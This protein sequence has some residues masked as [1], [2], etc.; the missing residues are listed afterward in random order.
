LRHEI[1]TNRHPT[2][3]WILTAAILLVLMLLPNRSVPSQTVTGSHQI[4]NVYVE[5]LQGD[6]SA[7]LIRTKLVQKLSRSQRFIIVDHVD[8]SDAILK[9]SAALWITGYYH[10]DIRNRYRTSGDTPVYTARL[11]LSLTNRQGNV[12]WSA[13]FKPRF[14]GSQYA[15]DNVTN[16]AI[17]HLEKIVK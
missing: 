7:A 13:S 1:A 2:R 5:A 16:Q 10:S 8:D 4:R 6:S 11:S 17:C 3:N 9:G 15:S 12:L 14:W